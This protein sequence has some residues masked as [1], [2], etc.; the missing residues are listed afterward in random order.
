MKIKTK[1]LN[2]MQNVDFNQI[3]P[4]F[5]IEGTIE[6]V[7]PLGNGLIN[8]TYLVV[9][10]EEEQPNYVLQ[11]INDSIFT[12]VELL[13]HNIE[14]VT[15]HIRKKLEAQGEEDIQRKVLQFVKTIDGK[16]YFMD[17]E[18]RFWR[19]M[20]F[21][22]NAQTFE[23]VDTKYSYL[24][25]VA[26]GDFE[27][28]LTDLPETLGDTIPDFHNME[29]RMKQLR[30]VVEKD[31]VGRVESVKEILDIFEKDAERMCQAE[32]LHRE[33]K[34]PKRICHCDTKVNNMMF[35]ANDGHFLLVIDLDT[36]MPSLFFSD[37]GDFLRSAANTTAED[38]PDM[39]NVH[40]N[41]DIFKAFTKG[42]IESAGK[43]LTPLEIELLP[44]AVELFPFM[45]SVRFMWDYLS[46]DHYWK[47]K[48]PTHNLDRSRNQLKLYQE[49]C[50][51]EQMMNDYIASLQI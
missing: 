34:L 18:R 2:I 24:A 33:G 28:M 49:V 19:I 8:D 25:G 50:K 31:P 22:P 35:D 44:Y 5:K 23:T 42:Y 1:N 51:H 7:K 48:Y 37:Y 26:F 16:N 36:V 45:Q 21:I 46:G 41:K 32:R 6:P 4:Q 47:C 17:K 15:N 13:Q 20:I 9:T 29:F 40:F 14:L 11:R 30:E 39:N 3:L 10:K 43:F 38:D 12:N 27:Q